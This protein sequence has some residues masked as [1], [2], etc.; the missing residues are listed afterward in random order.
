MKDDIK[1]SGSDEPGGSHHLLGLN[2]SITN[3]NEM[4]VSLLSQWKLLININDSKKVNSDFE[5]K[6]FFGPQSG[7]SI[8]PFYQNCRFQDI[9]YIERLYIIVYNLKVYNL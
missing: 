2:W 3:F 8:T 1:I 4:S 6:T 9:D 5:P 7:R